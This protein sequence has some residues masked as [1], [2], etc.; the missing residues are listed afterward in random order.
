MSAYFDSVIDTIQRQRWCSHC[1]SEAQAA[2]SATGMHTAILRN[3][4]LVGEAVKLCILR[5]LRSVEEPLSEEECCKF[6]GSVPDGVLKVGRTPVSTAIWMN[7]ME[8]VH[9]LRGAGAS[10]TV[11]CKTDGNQ[12]PLHYAVALNRIE[13]VKYI[14]PLLP[15]HQLLARTAS[16]DTALHVAARC[17]YFH[18]VELLLQRAEAL[19]TEDVF[20]WRQ[21]QHSAQSSTT[22]R[23][24]LNAQQDPP[25]SEF[26]QQMLLM[27][28][29]I[30]LRTTAHVLVSFS[31]TDDEAVASCHA[32]ECVLQAA[33]QH[34]CVRRLLTTRDMAGACLLTA[35]CS[36]PALEQLLRWH[37]SAEVAITMLPD[38]SAG[39]GLKK[40]RSMSSRDTFT[41]T[42][43]PLGQIEDELNADLHR[44]EDDPRCSCV[45][46]LCFSGEHPL[47][48]LAK[49]ANSIQS[50]GVV[51]RWLEVLAATQAPLSIPASTQGD[52]L[53]SPIDVSSPPEL[54]SPFAEELL[55]KASRGVAPWFAC[56][57]MFGLSTSFARDIV[58]LW[59]PVTDKEMVCPTACGELPLTGSVAHLRPSYCLPYEEY[60]DRF[61]KLSTATLSVRDLRNALHHASR[62]GDSDGLRWLRESVVEANILKP[63]EERCRGLLQQ[64]P[65]AHS[66]AAMTND[67]SEP[68]TPSQL[69]TVAPES[70][71]KDH[72]SGAESDTASNTT[73]V[74]SRPSSAA[75][76]PRV[77]SPLSEVDVARSMSWVASVLGQCERLYT[78][79]AN[80][81]DHD[82]M[83]PVA[84]AVVSD[85]RTAI[86][87]LIRLVEAIGRTTTICL[88]TLSKLGL[89]ATKAKRIHVAAAT[90]AAA[91]RQ[92]S[93]RRTNS[94]VS[95][96]PNTTT[97]GNAPVK[98]NPSFAAGN[99]TAMPLQRSPSGVN[100]LSTAEDLTTSKSGRNLTT[101]Q[102]FSGP[103]E[104]PISDAQQA[105]SS[106]AA[107]TEVAAPLVPPSFAPFLA[108][109]VEYAALED[110]S[111]EHTHAASPPAAAI[112]NHFSFG[113]QVDVG[114]ESRL[115]LLWLAQRHSIR[116]AVTLLRAAIEAKASQAAGVL[117]H[118]VCSRWAAASFAL[119]RDRV[120][121]ERCLH[122][123]TNEL[124]ST[125]KASHGI[126]RQW[127]LARGDQEHDGRTAL[128]TAVFFGDIKTLSGILEE[129]T[130]S[131]LA[132]AR[133]AG[134]EN[135]EIVSRS[136]S[137]ERPNDETGSAGGSKSFGS[138]PGSGERSLP[139]GSSFGDSH[140]SSS[141]GFTLDS[142]LGI[143]KDAASLWGGEYVSAFRH[144]PPLSKEAQMLWC[145][146]TRSHQ[147]S[148]AMSPLCQAPSFF[149]LAEASSRGD[150]LPTQSILADTFARAVHAEVADA[151]GA[152]FL[153]PC[154]DGGGGDG[155]GSSPSAPLP[156]MNDDT[157]VFRAATFSPAACRCRAM[158]E[159]LSHFF[160]LLIGRKLSS[161]VQVDGLEVSVEG[162]DDDVNKESETHCRTLTEDEDEPHTIE[163]IRSDEL[164]GV[165][166]PS[167]TD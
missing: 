29:G 78:L 92:G 2:F 150:F 73:G 28:S 81:K 139:L 94:G 55:L 34:K 87:E 98:R 93:I 147:P 125:E 166:Q 76:A 77:A 96:P 119:S 17:G 88:L 65:T 14:V 124:R 27:K 95:V 25:P 118:E 23:G 100:A 154:C 161:A 57:E 10:F 157:V 4:A 127:L 82:G 163:Q 148:D 43:G 86:V 38:E 42:D 3:D 47:Q 133:S 108:S 128:H 26:I 51:R 44:S 141:D 12:T 46:V 144:T 104:S 103:T 9:L 89:V 66:T 136:P 75:A 41:A 71:Q 33:H 107:V 130:N 140:V 70:Q 117:I 142:I 126:L 61:I 137:C 112:P 99:S 18:L 101:S 121:S 146:R 24:E 37:A 32:L 135:R 143:V 132:S 164:P 19:Y 7:S 69:L 145:K 11:A 165:Y 64:L 36:L 122:S 40:T 68:A 149:E 79:V 5:N 155:C 111:F 167:S 153:I 158:L 31:T 1:S 83:T 123:E 48:I 85:Q 39:S 63:M 80:G 84:H 59:C 109:V 6:E 159:L 72:M 56:T 67:G 49:H 22:P 16:G 15:K 105:S 30:D 90:A 74:S 50:Y 115:V 102:S 53:R 52:L 116:K 160:A 131:V 106:I 45:S 21:M 152:A 8:A 156:L 138:R 110:L 60:F 13:M 113:L 91:N 58:Q 62:L 151:L 134:S 20:V 162:R 120:L 129:L 35:T 97:A 54:L 114:I